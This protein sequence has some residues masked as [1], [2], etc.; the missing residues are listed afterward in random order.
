MAASFFHGVP[1]KLAAVTPIIIKI[2]LIAELL[3]NF[4]P[5][6]NLPFLSKVMEKVAAKQ[7]VTHK[8]VYKQS[9][10]L[11]TCTVSFTQLYSV[12]H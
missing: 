9:F 8:E 11:C 3:K 5:I 12:A 6:S 7:L 10:S 1:L 4:R 2:D